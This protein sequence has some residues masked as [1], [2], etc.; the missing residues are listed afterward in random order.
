MRGAHPPGSHQP[1][2]LRCPPWFG[3]GCDRDGLQVGAGIWF[4]REEVFPR[5]FSFSSRESNSFSS[6]VMLPSLSAAAP[7]GPVSCFCRFAQLDKMQFQGGI[8]PRSFWLGVMLR[9]LFF[10]GLLIGMLSSLL[11]HSWCVPPLLQP[12]SVLCYIFRGDFKCLESMPG[13]SHL[14]NVPG[15]GLSEQGTDSV[16]VAGCPRRA[17]G[18]PCA[19]TAGSRLPAGFVV[20]NTGHVANP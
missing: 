1:L 20:M 17:R 8:P 18:Q 10:R 13:G 5:G 3:E 19:G 9:A 7:V 2:I 6:T 16:S 11:H 12:S 4:S 14:G 15:W